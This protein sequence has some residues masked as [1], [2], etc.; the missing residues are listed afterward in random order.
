M[1]TFSPKAT[2]SVETQLYLFPLV[3]RLD[4]AILRP[5][6][7]GKIEPGEEFDP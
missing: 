6:L 4:A 3:H 7:F 2:G 1:T 5:P